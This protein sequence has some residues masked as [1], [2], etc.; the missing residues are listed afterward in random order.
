MTATVSA[1]KPSPP[2]LPPAAASD[3]SRKVPLSPSLAGFFLP[4]VLLLCLSIP[5]RLHAGENLFNSTNAIKGELG[6]LSGEGALFLA[7][8]VKPYLAESAAVAALFALTYVFDKDINF[9]FSGSHGGVMRGVTDFGNDASNPILHLGVAAAIYS[10]GIAADAPGY[11][12]LGEELGEALV[13]ADSATLVLKEV[14]GRGRPY[15]TGSNS[16]YRPF[17]FRDGYDSLPSMHTASSFAM[18]HVAASRTTGLPGKIAYYA[19]AA[20]AG[21][22]RVYQGKHWATDVLLGAA[23]GELAGDAVTRYRARPPGSLTVAPLAIDGNPALAL[24]G[25]F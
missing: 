13:I 3:G 11:A 20:L 2:P 17:Q 10:A 5:S 4:L 8:P 6:R 12:A 25:K 23:I 14:V 15:Q 21:F 1:Q 7:A 9:E 19:A 18:A 22:S 16:R 24:I